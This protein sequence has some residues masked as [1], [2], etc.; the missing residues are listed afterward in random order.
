LMRSQSPCLLLGTKPLRRVRILAVIHSQ[1]HR[2]Q[3]GPQGQRPAF[4][5]A[6]GEKPRRSD[7]RV[8][9]TVVPAAAGLIPGIQPLLPVP[10]RPAWPR[11]VMPFSSQLFM[12]AFCR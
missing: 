6:Q 8:V 10:P 5:L 1:P 7:R 11:A 9:A 12:L 2:P 4:A 3:F